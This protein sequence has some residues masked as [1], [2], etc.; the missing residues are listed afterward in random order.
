MSLSTISPQ[1][2]FDVRNLFRISFLHI[3]FISSP[4]QEHLSLFDI[5]C[6]YQC[7]DK[8]LAI[9]TPE[10]ALGLRPL[11]VRFGGDLEMQEF[12]ADLVHGVNSVHGVSGRAPSSQGSVFSVT[13]R[14]EVVVFDPQVAL[15]QDGEAAAAPGAGAKGEE[16]K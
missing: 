10:R 7:G 3:F 1:N 12:Q 8:T 6:V 11:L 14:G 5:T 13:A 15:Q 16:S 4:P 2:H 9:Q